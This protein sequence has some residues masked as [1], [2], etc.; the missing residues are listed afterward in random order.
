VKFGLLTAGIAIIVAAHSAVAAAARAA[1]RI[2]DGVK[3]S[4][5]PVVANRIGYL[6]LNVRMAGSLGVIFSPSMFKN[7][8]KVIGLEQ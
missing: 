5:I 1:L 2:M 8:N 7:A 4:G 3:P 6:V